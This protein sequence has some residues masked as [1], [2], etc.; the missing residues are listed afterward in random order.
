MENQFGPIYPDLGT[1][2]GKFRRVATAAGEIR[3]ILPEQR[4]AYGEAVE[5]AIRAKQRRV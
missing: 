1:G 5:R 2:I 4:R 3:Q